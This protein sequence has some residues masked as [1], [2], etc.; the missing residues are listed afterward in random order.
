MFRHVDVEDVPLR[1]YVLVVLDLDHL[2]GGMQW[3]RENVV[4][5]GL[6]QSCGSLRNRRALGVLA[7]DCCSVRVLVCWE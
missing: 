1:A 5:A 2:V 6:V 4:D 3:L 7:C